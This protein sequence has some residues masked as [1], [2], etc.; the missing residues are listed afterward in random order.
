[1]VENDR[2][3]MCRFKPD[4]KFPENLDTNTISMHQREGRCPQ[5]GEL[6]VIK[7]IDEPESGGTA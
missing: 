1:V 5:H 3:V 7:K 2:W 4:I 6:S